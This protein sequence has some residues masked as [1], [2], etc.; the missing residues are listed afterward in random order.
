MYINNDIGMNFGQINVK[1][2]YK[3]GKNKDIKKEFDRKCQI[4][5]NNIYQKVYKIIKYY[6]N[7]YIILNQ[8][9]YEGEIFVGKKVKLISFDETGKFEGRE[10][11][12]RFIGGIV[13]KGE[14]Y[15]E[16]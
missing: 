14:D 13:Y 4:N 12:A 7:S 11:Q 3:I 6:T 15:L 8:E 10:E 9:I 16:E 1:K 5:I 2:C